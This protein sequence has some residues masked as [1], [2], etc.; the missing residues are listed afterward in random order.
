MYNSDAFK[1]SVGIP[2]YANLTCSTFGLDSLE[3]CFDKNHYQSYG[4]INYQFN[5]IGYRDRSINQYQGNEILAI[6]DS[7]Y[8]RAR[9]QY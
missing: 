6:G 2:F 1:Q 9:S 7:F 3:H 5:E 8:C 4:E